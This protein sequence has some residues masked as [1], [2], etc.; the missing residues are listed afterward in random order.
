MYDVTKIEKKFPR[1]CER[2]FFLRYIWRRKRNYYSPRVYHRVGYSTAPI[3]VVRNKCAGVLRIKKFPKIN[4]RSFICVFR[5]CVGD[6][7]ERK[8]NRPR[9][10]PVI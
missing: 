4:Q 9:Q 3:S 6:T 1:A 2:L 8:K 5:N 7:I 10:K